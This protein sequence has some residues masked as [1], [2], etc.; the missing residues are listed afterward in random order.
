[1][2]VAQARVF[3]RYNRWAN[4]RLAAT[5]ATL[6]EADYRADRGLFFRSVHGTLN[7]L[8]VADRLWLLRI[9][10][11]IE[12]EPPRALDQ[13]L[14]DDRGDLE[15][16]RARQDERLT[17]FTDGLDDAALARPI[18]YRNLAGEAFRQPLALV[19]AHVFNHQTHHRGQIHAAL[20]MG[21]AAAPAL[22]LMYYLR[23]AG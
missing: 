20:T 4:A 22:D 10:G 2:L 5:V 16:A 3:A 23:E 13:S 17:A 6:A 1:M 21:G 15:V 9:G 8:L 18:A 19:L 14:H 12:G 11:E 7:H